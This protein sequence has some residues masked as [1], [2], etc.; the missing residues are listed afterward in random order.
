MIFALHETSQGIVAGAEYPRYKRPLTDGGAETWLYLTELRAQ[1]WRAGGLD[2]D[3]LW[4]RAEAAQV[5]MSMYDASEVDFVG[6]THTEDVPQGLD[7]RSGL[8]Y[9]P[10]FDTMTQEELEELLWTTDNLSNLDTENLGAYW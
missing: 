3:V 8:A 9:D 1:A 7:L 6:V 2:P 5:C 10:R 4:S